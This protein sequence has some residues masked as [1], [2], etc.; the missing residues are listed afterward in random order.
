[1][2]ISLIRETR[3]SDTVIVT[4]TLLS[5]SEVILESIRELYLPREI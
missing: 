4:A 2:L 5:V 1:M 3:P